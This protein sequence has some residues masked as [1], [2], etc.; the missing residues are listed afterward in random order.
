MATIFLSYAREDFKKAERIAV[1]LGANGHSV[2]WDRN[3]HAGSRFNK[4]IDAALRSADLVMVLWSKSSVE[5]AWVHDEAA[6]GRDSG[7]LVPVLLEPIEPP[8]G[9][10]QYQALDL[11]GRASQNDAAVS[12]LVAAIAEKLGAEI[13]A[14]AAPSPRFA[15]EPGRAYLLIGL[16]AVVI[17]AAALWILKP[18]SRARPDSIVVAAAGQAS[19]PASE[20]W[21]GTSPSIW[22]NTAPALSPL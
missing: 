15:W 13:T 2:W 4:E 16:V 8:L 18:W 19:N 5:S 14:P 12:R 7:R 11:V 6:A 9:F 20:A 22:R 17:A 10:R 3:I 1:A 21:R